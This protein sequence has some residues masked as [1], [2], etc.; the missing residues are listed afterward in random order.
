MSIVVVGSIA[1]DDVVTENKT[2]SNALGG[3]ALY[4]ATAASHFAPV[5]MIGIV[6]DDFPMNELDFLK[7]RGVD[8]EGIEVIKG[9]KTFRWGGEYECD[10]NNRKTTNLEL[11]VFE[12]FN[13]VLDEKARK[14]QSRFCTSRGLCPAL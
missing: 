1:F 13:P 7:E 6:G 11:N 12:N 8:T 9:G 3:S 4:F 10:M 2:V 5:Q 14:S